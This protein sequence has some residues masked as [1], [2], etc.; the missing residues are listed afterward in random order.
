MNRKELLDEVVE[1]YG[2]EWVEES[3]K[4]EDEE[5]LWRVCQRIKRFRVNWEMWDNEGIRVDSWEVDSIKMRNNISLFIVKSGGNV[6]PIEVVEN[7]IWVECILQGENYQL[8]R[9]LY[10][11]CLYHIYR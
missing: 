7:G 2:M 11:E 10:D 6:S 8:Q 4:C 9:Y 3:K 5:F 1:V